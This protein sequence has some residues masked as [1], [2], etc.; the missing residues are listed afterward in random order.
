MFLERILTK[1]GLDVKSGETPNTNFQCTYVVRY[2]GKAGARDVVRA[3]PVSSRLASARE[4]LHDTI[5]MK[6]PVR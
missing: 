6:H 3:E 2:V 1:A 4:Q 5:F